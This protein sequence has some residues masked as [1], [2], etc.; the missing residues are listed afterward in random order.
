MYLYYAQLR[1]KLAHFILVQTLIVKQFGAFACANQPLIK[2]LQ[3]CDP[4]HQS[5][6]LARYLLARNH[7]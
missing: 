1:I 4:I 6:L 2:D 5:M 7:L 3:T